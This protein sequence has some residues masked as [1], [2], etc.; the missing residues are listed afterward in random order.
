VDT[1]GARAHPPAPH[2]RAA[3][4]TRT[5]A[6]STQPNT[7]LYV[8]NL[9]DGVAKQELRAQLYALFTTYGAVLDVVALK[10]PRMKGQAFLVFAELAAATAAMRALEGMVFYEKP[11]VCAAR[12]PRVAWCADAG[13]RRLSNMQRQSPTRR[14]DGTTRIG[15]RR[16]PSKLRA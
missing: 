14:P 1:F 5:M 10:G 12:I 4:W 6:A 9:N 7:T 15:C 13:H 16:L 8:K 3:A 11:M 2:R